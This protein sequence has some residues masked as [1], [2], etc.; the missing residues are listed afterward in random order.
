[1]QTCNVQLYSYN[2]NEAKTY[3]AALLFVV[4]NVVLPQLF[5]QFRMGG[6]TWLPIYFFT[7]IG[8]FKYGKNVGVLTA[9]LSPI[10]NSM[11]FG[12]PNTAMLPIILIKSTLLALAASYA[13]NKFKKINLLI[14]A[15]VILFYQT[16]GALAEWAL[17]QNLQ[18]AL[19]NIY[20][21]IPGMLLQLLGGYIFIQYIIRK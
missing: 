7:L 4:G 13:A 16:I 9:L 17:T 6:P 3:L 5:H 21:A 2:Y 11:L 20:I 18:I 8:A 19:Q 15:G 12:M 14:L 10:I 1:M